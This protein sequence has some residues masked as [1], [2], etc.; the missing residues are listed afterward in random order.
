M[1]RLP[2]LRS[3]PFLQFSNQAVTVTVGLRFALQCTH[4]ALQ[5][6]AGLRPF[7]LEPEEAS[8]VLVLGLAR[9]SFQVLQLCRH[10]F[11]ALLKL[12]LVQF[13]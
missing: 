3:L 7:L 2:N 8:R 4:H 5:L 11:L 1:A 6:R 12:L 10:L 13:A 9:L